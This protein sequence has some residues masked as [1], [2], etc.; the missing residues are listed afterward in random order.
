MGG[1]GRGLGGVLQPVFWVVWR[2]G[3]GEEEGDEKGV[4]CVKFEPEIERSI[5]TAISHNHHHLPL[6]HQPY[7]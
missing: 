7:K 6:K 4:S 3:E 5:S 1:E 2:E